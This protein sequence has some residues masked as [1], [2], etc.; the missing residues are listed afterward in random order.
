MMKFVETHNHLTGW[1]PD[2]R[3][4]FDE[5]EAI[6][7]ERGLHGFAISDHHDLDVLTTEKNPWEVDVASYVETFYD[8]RRMPSKRS[9]G[10]K[11]GFLLSLELG[12]TPHNGAQLREVDE[13]YPFDYT[14]VAVHFYDGYDPYLH[15]DKIYTRDFNKLYTSTINMIEQSA[16]E[17]S[18]SRIVAHYDYFSR[19]APEEKSKMLY[20]HTPDS[21]DKLFRTMRDNEQILE[22]NTGTIEALIRDKGY[23][24]EEAMPDSD[25]LIRYRE[26]GG[27]FLTV[28]SDAHRVEQ[29]GRYVKDTIAY[30]NSLGFEEF[31]WF[32]ERELHYSRIVL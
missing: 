28:A 11:P 15:K 14:I 17:L 10:D 30:L 27:R 19:Y 21:F 3:Q 2:A 25:V 7:I 4:T 31:A 5:L 18:G 1:S 8:R 12:W 20:K 26:L 6:S 29:N 13:Q 22:I 23:T 32:E 16:R 24:L 9:A